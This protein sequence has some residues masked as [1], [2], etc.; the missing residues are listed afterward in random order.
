MLGMKSMK[1]LEY[2]WLDGY[3][4]EPS[5]RSKIKVTKDETPPDWSFD[6]SSTRQAEGAN[7]DCLL[8]PVQSY[9]GPLFADNLIMC[10]VQT[11]ERETHVT[12]T[13]A[14]AAAVAK[15]EWWFG[16]EQ[17]YFFTTKGGELLGWEE[18]VP[19]PQGD[20]YCGVG[21]SNV[22]GREISEVHLEA[23]LEA[24]IEITGTNAEVALGQ[25]EYQCFG[26][27]VKAADDLWVSRYL[28]YKI[29]EEYDVCVN[30]HPKPKTGDW[31]GSGM[32][33]NFSNEEMRTKGTENLYTSICEKLGKVHKKGIDAYGSDNDMRLT[34]LHET[35]SIDQFSYGVSDRGASIRIPIY[36][37]EHDW[38]GYLEDRRPASNADPYKI[39]AHIVG[40][41]SK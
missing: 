19:R 40:T 8:L 7:S 25:W 16:F 34:G 2:I 21:A 3:Q 37:V 14:A 23:C 36:T 15:D 12:N 29:A 27:G 1:I 22:E 39:I 38:N 6:G 5:L 41:L 31:N 24:G 18:G 11:G 26:K 30:I 20:Y 28:L 4:P 10:E 35:Q 32:H 13:R 17:E 9:E 33:A